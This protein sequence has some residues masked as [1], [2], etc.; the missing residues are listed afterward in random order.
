MVKAYTIDGIE[1]NPENINS[2]CP[3]QYYDKL[4]EQCIQ[5]YKNKLNVFIIVCSVFVLIWI[6][7]IFFIYSLRKSILYYQKK[8]QGNNF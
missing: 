7:S 1:I 4:T 2:T 3:S 5:D 8:I 6:V